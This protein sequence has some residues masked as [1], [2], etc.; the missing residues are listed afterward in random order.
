ML[1]RVMDWLDEI[2]GYDR[3]GVRV[4]FV[5][6]AINALFIGLLAYDW[7]KPEACDADCRAGVE[8]FIQDNP[9]LFQPAPTIDTEDLFREVE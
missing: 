2:T 3:M 8:Q 9:N 6:L 5:I 4:I 7:L 1:G